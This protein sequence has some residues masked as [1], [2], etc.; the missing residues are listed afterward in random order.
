MLEF[1][2]MTT[3]IITAYK[4]SITV[5]KAVLSICEANSDIADNLEVIVV[6][7]DKETLTSAKEQIVSCGWKNFQIIQD[8]GNGKPDAINMAVEKANGS[9]L[10]LTDGDMYISGNSVKD[11]IKHFDKLE[12]GGVSG[13]PISDDPRE[14]RFGYYSH[15]FCEAAHQ[16]R[17]GD[18][19]VPMS[20]YL[21]AIRKF[22]WLFPI[23]NELRAED[24][25]ISSR[26]HNEGKLILYE[27]K[28]LAYVKFPKNL[29]D[30]IKQKTRSLGGNVQLS[31][32]GSLQKTR[33]IFEDLK[34]AFFP[35]FFAKNIKEFIY[36][37]ELYPIRLF[38]WIKIYSIHK[39]NK[40]KDGMWERIESSKS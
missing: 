8:K 25:Y 28:A 38:L 3:I 30:W 31:N 18:N 19:F 39:N 36:S 37:A 5:K 7:P 24:A 6:A 2:Q 1:R 29:S 4:E 14:K 10:I 34:M 20:G 16:K 22:D 13:H 26:I 17:I 9:I 15:L 12:V 23:P 33:S 40:Y 11:L 27:P 35:I 21:Y 32:F